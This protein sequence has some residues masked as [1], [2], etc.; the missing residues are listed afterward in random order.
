MIKRIGIIGTGGVGGY[1]GAKLCQLLKSD[2]E[3]Q[4]AFLARGS[5][6]DQIQACGLRVIAQDESEWRVQPT[7][8]TDK[9]SE[10]GC[11]DLV[12]LC[13]KEFD[14]YQ[15][16]SELKDGRRSFRVGLLGRLVEGFDVAAG[17]TSEV[18]ALGPD[19]HEYRALLDRITAAEAEE[20]MA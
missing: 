7:L 5:H 19:P 16:L 2:T 6:L 3:L 18:L 15:V 13:V 14:L 11:L 4:V 10:L 9:I 1:F 20:D 12:F 17:M 8:A